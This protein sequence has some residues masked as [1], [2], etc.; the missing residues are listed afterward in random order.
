MKEILLGILGIFGMFW[1]IFLGIFG[2]FNVILVIILTLILVRKLVI[3]IKSSLKIFFNFL[4]ALIKSTLNAIHFCTKKSCDF[5]VEQNKMRKV[6]TIIMVVLMSLAIIGILYD[7]FMPSVMKCPHDL[8]QSF[9]PD[10]IENESNVLRRNINNTDGIVNIDT[11]QKDENVEKK[12]DY[13]KK[14][15]FDSATYSYNV[16]NT[17]SGILVPLFTFI[18]LFVAWRTFREERTEHKN[19]QFTNDFFNMLQIQKTL[20]NE[21]KGSFSVRYTIKENATGVSYFSVAKKELKNIFDV[22]EGE[23]IKS[24]DLKYNITREYN[25]NAVLKEYNDGNQAEKIKISYG[26]FLEK[27][28][29][30]NSYFRHLYHILKRLNIEEKT[31]RGPENQKKNEIKQYSDILQATLTEDELVFVNYNCF[32]FE[33][34]RK[35]VLQFNFLSNLSEEKLLNKDHCLSKKFENHEVVD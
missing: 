18:A 28:P 16:V 7:A 9:S 3:L 8:V 4:I 33:N 13:I 11:K 31:C 26:A 17:I 30:L 21:L 14:E 10:V 1:C 2:M 35:L 12:E 29:E 19:D 5:I 32:C 23:N 27:H 6:L 24:E 20:R 22:L 25:L 34:T 15:Y